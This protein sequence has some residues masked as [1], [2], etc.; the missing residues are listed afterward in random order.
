[1]S[2]YFRKLIVFFIVIYVLFTPSI[3]MNAFADSQV[4]A[5]EKYTQKTDKK[6]NIDAQVIE[7]S[8]SFLNPKINKKINLKNTN[9]LSESDA[10]NIIASNIQTVGNILSSSPS[11]LAEQAKS[12]ALGKFNGTVSSEA[13]KWLSQFGTA[14]INFGLDKKGT[15][16]ENSLDL[17]LPLYDNKTDWL[18]FSQL[19]YRN[20]DSRN[21]INVGLGGRYFYQNWM[22]GLNTFYDHDI[23]GKNQRMG[24]GGE[25]WGDYIKLS[26]NTY[27]RL[28]DLQT[29]RNFKDYHERPA[30]G[31]DINGEF[32]LPAYPNLGAKL[33]YEQYFGENV[34]LFNRDTRQKNPS[35]AKLGLTYTPIPLVT[36]GVDYK[37]GESGHTE[38]QFLAN[39]SYKLGVPFSSQLS[40]ESVASMRTLAGSRYDLVERNNNIVLDHIKQ[41][42]IQLS[43]PQTL[44]GYSHEEKKIAATNNP[45]NIVKWQ[46]NKEYTKFINDG[47]KLNVNGNQISIIFPTY[48]LGTGKPNNYPINFN[49][50]ENSNTKKA[51]HH[52]TMTV[53]VRPFIVKEKEV[54]PTETLPAD[55][56]QTYQFT[57]VITYDAVGNQP[58]PQVT[59]D[60]VQWTTEPEIG[61]QSGLQWGKP[62]K[63]SKT[64]DKGQLQAALTSSR[65][66]NDV[67]VF[68]QMD[69]MDK[70]QVGTVSFGDDSTRLH[71]DKIGVSLPDNMTTPLIADGIQAYTYKAVVLDGDNNPVSPNTSISHVKW[72]HDQEGIST[73]K[74]EPK[75]NKT[76]DKGQLTATLTSSAE[77]PVNVIVT[78]SI[79]GHPEKSADP[80]SFKPAD[81]S[82][83]PSPSGAILVGETYTVTATINDK[84]SPITWSFDAPHRDKVTSN[85][86]AGNPVATFSSSVEQI[87]TV[88]ASISGSKLSQKSLDFK[89]PIIHEPTF[90]PKSGTIP[91]DGDI[92]SKH[93]YDY[94]AE[95][96]GTDGLSYTGKEIKFKW[97]L[98]PLASGEAPKNTWLSETGEVT[99]QSDGKLK[100]QLKSSQKSPVV[101]GAIVCLSVVD[102]NPAE[103]SPTKQCAQPV[104]FETPAPVEDLKII[105]LTSDFN[106]NSPKVGGIGGKKEKY[107]YKA[108]VKSAS[109]TSLPNGHKINGAK[110]ST[111][112]TTKTGDWEIKSNNTVEDSQITATLTS[113]AGIGDVKGGGVTDGLIVK[114]EV[115]A[116]AGKTDS[117]PAD[118]VVFE[119]PTVPAGI[120]VYSDDYPNGLIFQE[121]NKPYNA[122]NGMK[123]KLV[124]PKPSGKSILENQGKIVSIG[125]YDPMDINSTIGTIDEK[126]GEITFTLSNKVSIAIEV[127]MP[128]KARYIYSYNFDIRR[129][130]FSGSD[131]GGAITPNTGHSCIGEYDKPLARRGVENVTPTDLF[132]KQGNNVPL[133]DEIKN[134]FSWGILKYAGSIGYPPASSLIVG[135]YDPIDVSRQFI[136]DIDKHTIVNNDGNNLNGYLLCYRH[137]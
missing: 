68:L 25:I 24:V 107:T 123:G 98:K 112:P 76:D 79:E 1:M 109:G 7:S 28:S 83:V 19:G 30:N 57:P 78:L 111:D 101:T 114:L 135:S 120:H 90:T 125:N 52:E 40:P 12:Y 29:S 104:N 115:P 66:I 132:L 116:G 81:I 106:V 33:T 53:I 103:V 46:E 124:K 93:A 41:S 31:Y 44:T 137:P 131:T 15:L 127:K 88:K 39:L 99:A 14:R 47:G 71:I 87:V 91:P 96:F 85:Y 121:Q 58:L 63:T 108:I 82:L 61:E 23:T 56:K 45:E 62:E 9:A 42:T 21:T 20:K 36:M 55:G 73:L 43:I 65:P 18:F 37:Q 16:Q 35:L 59:L 69:G 118:P 11:E 97:W 105:S 119:T 95:V 60:N 117:M 75:G 8:K 86:T 94:I 27:Y 64:N 2:S 5:D 80:V 92:N 10:P 54:N 134:V 133:L 70:T 6:D 67:K 110:W 50:F 89:W 26:A 32:F 113:Q 49:I 100:V 48:Q 22:Y 77:K 72:G 129:Y 74:L 17:L 128:S 126:T 4:T 136:Y 102:G 13:Q 38:T 3:L 84:N 51:S 34:T 130:F 122:F